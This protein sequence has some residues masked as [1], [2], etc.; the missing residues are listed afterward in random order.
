MEQHA[1]NIAILYLGQHND[2]RVGSTDTR[3]DRFQ[4]QQSI[5]LALPWTVSRALDC[6]AGGIQKEPLYV[7]FLSK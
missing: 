4:M 1:T 7:P 5:G 2:V 6:C 3:S